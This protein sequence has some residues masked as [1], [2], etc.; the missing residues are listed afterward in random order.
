MKSLKVPFEFDPSGRVAKVEGEYP[1]LATYI[2][3]LLLT[4]I[5]ERVMRPEYGSMVMESVFEPMGPRFRAELEADIQDAMRDWSPETEV[6]RIDL[7]ERESTLS[8]DL[9]FRARSN[10][11]G[12]TST[13]SVEIDR[14]GV[15][16]ET[17]Q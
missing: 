16:E 8:V 2:R 4:R 5:G 17:F 13:L 6:T 3:T 1:V 9:E 14:G 7:Q 12:E 15:V 11:S 10:L